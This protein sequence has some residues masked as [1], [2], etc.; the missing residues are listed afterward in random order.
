MLFPKN[1]NQLIRDLLLSLFSFFFYIIINNILLHIE[2]VIFLRKFVYYVS[3][4]GIFCPVK[5]IFSSLKLGVLLAD[6]ILKLCI[7]YCIIRFLDKKNILH[8]IFSVTLIFDFTYIILCFFPINIDF[9]FH[10]SRIYL[11]HSLFGYPNFIAFLV[12]GIIH[13]LYVLKIGKISANE[14][15]TYIFYSISSFIFQF[16]FIH[17]VLKIP[18]PS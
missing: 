7:F 6:T 2:Y 12:V 10:S 14:L 15:A 8:T 4:Y 16:W 13:I 3:S 17:Y 5:P 9:Y 1:K 11:V 18:I